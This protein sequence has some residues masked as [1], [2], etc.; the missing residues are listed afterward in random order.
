MSRTTA[1]AWCRAFFSIILLA[2]GV[3]HADE[4]LQEELLK[5]R[6]VNLQTASPTKNFLFDGVSDFAWD[7]ETRAYVI[8]FN[9]LKKSDFIEK[10]GVWSYY[11]PL[12]FDAEKVDFTTLDDNGCG[13]ASACNMLFMTGWAQLAGYSSEDELFREFYEIDGTAN[14][15]WLSVMKHVFK[16]LPS[17]NIWNYYDDLQMNSTLFQTIE[18]LLQNH[19]AVC[20]LYNH[21][22][23]ASHKGN[24]V[25][26]VW[27]LLS[28]NRYPTSDPR[29]Y[30]AMIVSDSDDDKWGYSQASDAPNRLKTVPLT[31]NATEQVFY[32]DDGY[33]T[34]GCTLKQS[35]QAQERFSLRFGNDQCSTFSIGQNEEAFV[36]GVSGL[37]YRSFAPSTSYSQPYAEFQNENIIDAEKYSSFSVDDWWC[38]HF[39]NVNQLVY[40]GWAQLAGYPDEDT[41]ALELIQN[42]AW[43]QQYS[44]VWKYVFAKLPSYRMYDYTHMFRMVEN[45]GVSL[46]KTN[47]MSL[48][49]EYMQTSNASVYLQLDWGT[50]GNKTGSHAITLY[51]Y[52][53]D[54]SFPASDPR[55]FSGVIVSDS[56]NDKHGANSGNL[57]PNSMSII[58]IT[59]DDTNKVYSIFSNTGI[60]RFFWGLDNFPA[61][62]L[63]KLLSIRVEGESSIPYNSTA[64]Y[65]CTATWENGTTVVVPDW[66]LSPTAYAFV[67]RSGVVTNK[68]ITS[69]NQSV[70][71]YAQFNSGDITKTASKTIT[72]PSRTLNG[73]AIAGPSSIAT[74]KTAS[75]T[76]TATW[77]DGSSATVTP[78]WSLNSTTYATVNANGIVTNNN[79][80]TTSQTVTLTAKYTIGSVT[81]T[82]TLSITLTRGTL[83][84]VGISGPDT[85]ADGGNASYTCT[86][87]WDDGSSMEVEPVWSLS[88]TVYATVNANGNVTCMNS[89]TQEQRVTLRASYTN[90]SITRTA[91]KTIV[92]EPIAL[93]SLK[94]QGPQAI[95]ADRTAKYT[96]IVTFS[97]GSTSSVSPT[98]SLSVA[99]Y[100][101]VNSQGQVTNKNSTVQDQNVTLRANYIY[102]GKTFSVGKTI[103]LKKLS[104]DSLTIGGDASVPNGG[105]ATYTCTANWSSG[106]STIVTPIWSLSSTRYASIAADGKLTNKNTSVEIQSVVLTAAYTFQNVKTTV[107]KTIQLQGEVKYRLT[108]EKGTGGGEYESGTEIT[109]TAT[110]PLAWQE[111]VQ[112]E[113]EG[114]ELSE[115]QRKNP[116]VTFR[117]PKNDVMFMAQC[118]NKTVEMI[119]KLRPGWNLCAFSFAPDAESTALLLGSGDC[120][121]WSQGTFV[122][123]TSFAPGE[124]FWL[125]SQA[126]HS[127]TL[128]GEQ[129]EPVPLRKGW[130]LILPSVYPPVEPSCL[131]QVQGDSYI[132]PTGEE[133]TSEPVWFFL[134]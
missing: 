48:L 109:V 76:C 54:K 86:A 36:V 39:T 52:T 87:T 44:D 91:A 81:K 129:G 17:E 77:S 50:Y 23:P 8:F 18:S 95:V 14:Y 49:A 104:L 5:G 68:N 3:L 40:A 116:V 100:A 43:E 58:P 16:K 13:E 26:T 102:G 96:C 75:Y 119:L 92:L 121:R 53:V 90:G 64:G 25:L 56:D 38:Q 45:S 125:H 72:I 118:R 78:I 101:S 94:I 98:W 62:S 65:T 114:L 117:M 2:M 89:T 11:N 41:L 134:K 124:G 9:Q 123:A 93:T 105:S 15:G 71:L 28:D 106:A 31:W 55:Y 69:Q 4:V 83:I 79:P 60:I 7:A 61:Q 29:H 51:G 88:S 66:S 57:A 103:T 97:N 30:T 132:C 130:N 70:T 24:H 120:Y 22:T 6:S 20:V 107:E 42:P 110:E 67:D 10:N 115:E 128:K 34:E 80:T 85:I 133:V 74:G 112:W 33:I 46:K 59:W 63:G 127:L 113:V 1:S 32:C 131:F 122:K 84:S 111:F 19:Q 99:S 108:V 35:S 12:V 82:A 126:S 47:V 21:G 27:G 37:T 73:I